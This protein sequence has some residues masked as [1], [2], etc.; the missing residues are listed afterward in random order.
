MVS[1]TTDVDNALRP[2]KGKETESNINRISGTNEK[3]KSKI[4]YYIL[5]LDWQLE[6]VIAVRRL[7]IA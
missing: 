1:N 5:H 2:A 7:S 4:K 6:F 3:K